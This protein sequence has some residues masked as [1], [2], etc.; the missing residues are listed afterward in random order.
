MATLDTFAAARPSRSGSVFSTL[1]GRVI[2]WN[3]RRMTLRMLNGL[4]DHELEDIGLERGNLHA[5]VNR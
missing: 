1:L 5:W 4:T 2:A 3:D